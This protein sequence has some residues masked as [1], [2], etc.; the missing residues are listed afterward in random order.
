VTDAPLKILALDGSPGGSGR[1]RI[2][3]DAV[4]QGAAQAGATVEAL[5]LAGGAPPV[6]R[7]LAADA[8]V[9]GSPIYRASYA[10]PLKAFLDGC[11]RG[12]WGETEAP[13]TGRG[14][15]LVATGAT[16]HHYL[17]LDDL[18]NVLAGFFAA[19]PLSPGLYVPGEGFVDPEDGGPRRLAD[20]FAQAATAQGAALVALAR[21]VAA[22]P[23]LRAITPQA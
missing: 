13:L 5:E 18:R 9:L 1:T 16:W 2:A 22:A 3:L 10:T 11:P 4:L 14:V 19:H 23:E 6:E 7:L 8:F 21:A 17:A 12:M 15:A 20:A